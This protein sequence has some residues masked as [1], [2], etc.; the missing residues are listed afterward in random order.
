MQLVQRLKQVPLTIPDNWDVRFKTLEN[1][2][3]F[4]LEQNTDLVKAFKEKDAEIEKDDEHLAQGDITSMAIP[5]EDNDNDNNDMTMTMTKVIEDQKKM[6]IDNPY[7]TELMINDSKLSYAEAIKSAMPPKA[8]KKYNEKALQR[9]EKGQD[10]NVN[11]YMETILIQGIHANK[12]SRIRALIQQKIGFPSSKIERIETLSRTLLAFTMPKSIISEFMEKFTKT[13]S[14]DG[15]SNNSNM[16]II[17]KD[18]L[19]PSSLAK[20][21]EFSSDEECIKRAAEMVVSR[22][23]WEKKKSGSKPLIKYLNMMIWRAKDQLESGKY[24]NNDE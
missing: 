1:R 24:T 5:Q 23:K 12:Y 18:I 16:S 19:D 4:I 13:Y 2:L 17:E 3:T 10:P 11:D 15:D 6:L 14:Q 21:K 22:M 8:Y 20:Y 7:T 9:I